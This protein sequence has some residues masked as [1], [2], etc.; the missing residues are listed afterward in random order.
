MVNGEIDG[1]ILSGF[2]FQVSSVRC[3]QVSGG[4]HQGKV[5]VEFGNGNAKIETKESKT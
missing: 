5:E 1:G 2:R 4:R 3:F